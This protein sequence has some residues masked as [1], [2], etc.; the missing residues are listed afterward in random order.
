MG[1]PCKGQGLTPSQ[2]QRT[3]EPAHGK[4]KTSVSHNCSQNICLNYKAVGFE[5]LKNHPQISL[6]SHKAITTSTRF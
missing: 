1:L 2:G 5:C 3:Q 4:E 6:L